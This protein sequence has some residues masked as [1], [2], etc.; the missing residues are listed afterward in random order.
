MDHANPRNPRHARDPCKKLQHAESPGSPRRPGRDV[1][2]AGDLPV[3]G[4]G[5][6]ASSLDGAIDE[7][8]TPARGASPPA[9]PDLVAYRV[10]E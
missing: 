9:A 6:P 5:N 4:G 3:G 2:V 10:D 7:V 1:N 8:A